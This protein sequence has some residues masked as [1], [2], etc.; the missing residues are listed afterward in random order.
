MFEDENLFFSTM[1]NVQVQ[2]LSFQNTVG[3]TSAISTTCDI[4][5]ELKIS[6]KFRK[7]R[8]KNK[9]QIFADNSF[10]AA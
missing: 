7:K 3:A 9:I 4:S 6:D 1:Q 10:L 8:I 5:V 2:G